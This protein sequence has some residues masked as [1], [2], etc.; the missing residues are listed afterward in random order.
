[1]SG[2]TGG[3][4]QAP[5]SLVNATNGFSNYFYGWGGEDKDFYHR[6][7]WF[8]WPIDQ[9]SKSVDSD[10]FINC[11]ETY[12]WRK[13]TM[14]NFRRDVGN[15]T[16]ILNLVEKERFE[17]GD[18]VSSVGEHIEKYEVEEYGMFSKLYVTLN[19]RRYVS[20][21]YDKL[22]RASMATAKARLLNRKQHRQE[23]RRRSQ[24]K[25][26]YKLMEPVY[27]I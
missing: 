13:G 1:M 20:D 3:V 7:T 22:A 21:K 26:L 18:G 15:E 27:V 17:G 10:E 2:F 23:E 5:S 14:T 19:G 11:D 9:L 25:D 16:H 12:K 8:S 4:F 24:R 6:T